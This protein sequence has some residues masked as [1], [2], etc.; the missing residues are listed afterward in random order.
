MRANTNTQKG[1]LGVANEVGPDF[2]L[3]RGGPSG[4]GKAGLAARAQQFGG[5]GLDSRRASGLGEHGERREAP[6]F[7][8]ENTAGRGR[9]PALRRTVRLQ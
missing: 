3:H 6:A 5:G 8:T 1:Y 2:P 9:L 7:V 4:V